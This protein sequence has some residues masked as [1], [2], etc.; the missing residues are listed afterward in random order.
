MSLY[1]I[2]Y[3]HES[4][5]AVSTKPESSLDSPRPPET[6]DISG[7]AGSYIT[8]PLVST[9]LEW[10]LLEH[11]NST[12]DAHDYLAQRNNNDIG[13]IECEKFSAEIFKKYP[14]LSS[15]LAAK[16]A[17]TSKNFDYI[18][19]NL[20][21]QNID[22][23]LIRHDLDLTGDKSQIDTFCENASLSCT[24]LIASYPLEIAK[25]HCHAYIVKYGIE[26][27]KPKNLEYSDLNRFKN[28]RWWKKKV[29]VLS[30]R[31]IE[32]VR[33]NLNIVNS[34]NQIYASDYSV[35]MRKQQKELSR[36]YLESTYIQNDAGQ[37]YNLLDIS[38][39]SVSNPKVRRAEL[40]TRISGFDQVAEFIGD[41]GIFITVNTPSRM[42]A[43]IKNTGKPNPK[44]DGTDP[45]QAH[46]YLTHIWA[47]I[48][49]ELHRR[50]IQ[51]YGFRIV[52]PHH[53]G[54][55]HWHLLLFVAPEQK[56]ELANTVRH[57][58]LLD[59][60]YEKGAQKVRTQIVDI[61]STRGSAAG[62]IAKYVSKNIDGFGIDED[63]EGNDSI[64]ASE[65]IETWASNYGIRQ[66][67]QIG[68]ASVTIWREL[69][70]LKESPN[71]ELEPFRHAADSG[72]WAAYTMLMNGPISKRKN[73]KLQTWYEK[74]EVI[75][76]D[77]GEI[78]T[79]PKT[80]YGDEAPEILIG[81]RLG[82]ESIQTRDRT[83]QLVAPIHAEQ[84]VEHR[85]YQPHAPP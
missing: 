37:I 85:L 42:H 54:T 72:D 63:L 79:N 73:R 19:A 29:Y 47:L 46:Q 20:E 50:N 55:P 81:I 75:D 23:L 16:Y 44:F 11:K 6:T 49:A 27:E 30:R 51:P 7:S 28:R 32:T 17:R 77:T 62:Y 83:W 2:C 84:V 9:G 15:S 70:R 10:P 43:T 59:S 80:I 38:S 53:D 40:M 31:T 4:S 5:P 18:Q 68:G 52:E 82:S 12:F 67:Q 14:D 13:N 26:I 25:N 33:R 69:R 66:F 34:K 74:N 56:K 58:S 71:N 21:L 22:S 60:P 35:R 78:I 1:T 41:E 45:R 64:S 3:E 76:F 61:D 57:Y 39:R 36:Q 48:R 8:H 24:K 65:R